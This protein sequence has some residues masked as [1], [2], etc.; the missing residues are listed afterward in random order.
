MPYASCLVS[1]SVIWKCPCSPACP[2]VLSL[3]ELCL[4]EDLGFCSPL[5]LGCFALH[6][7]IACLGYVHYGIVCLASQA[8]DWFSFVRCPSKHIYCKPDNDWLLL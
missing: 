8:P 4:T 1:C 7:G 5:Y 6:P 2:Q 3:M